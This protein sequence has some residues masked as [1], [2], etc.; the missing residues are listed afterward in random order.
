MPERKCAFPYEVFPNFKCCDL[1]R[2]HAGTTSRADLSLKTKQKLLIIWKHS[3]ALQ[4][5]C[6]W[7]RT[8]DNLITQGF[9]VAAAWWV[10]SVDI[11]LRISGGRHGAKYKGGR[12]KAQSGG[13]EAGEVIPARGCE[14][15]AIM[16]GRGRGPE[17][18]Q[19]EL[20]DVT[21]YQILK[22]QHLQTPLLSV[23]MGSEGS[24]FH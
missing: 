11:W 6:K 16:L 12:K 4:W 17:A 7:L 13:I 2:K 19:V 22:V 24:A 5:L 8:T 3:N 18:E 20:I 14:Q 23:M 10:V 9:E 1:S 21:A 15:R